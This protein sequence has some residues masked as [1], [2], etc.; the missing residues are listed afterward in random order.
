M[1]SI[2]LTILSMYSI[3]LFS[4]AD[5]L[6]IPK[7]VK[8][9][10][11]LQDLEV[12]SSHKSQL[13][14][15]LALLSTEKINRNEL[16]KAACCNVSESFSTNPSVDIT[17][18]DAATGAKQI[19]LL[20]LSGSYVQLQTENIPNLRGLSSNYGMDFI[21][22]TW[23]ESIQITKGTGSVMNGYEAM[24]GQIN[25][26]Y[27]KPFTSDPISVNVYANDAGR[28]EGNTEVSIRLNPN[29]GTALML[30]YSKD[31]VELDENSDG[32]SDLPMKTQYNFLNRWFY[33]K[34]GYTFQAFVKAVSDDRWSG[35]LNKK[36]NIDIQT[37]RYEFFVKNGYVFNTE[38]Y[39][40]LGFILSGNT[41]QQDAIYGNSSFLGNQNNLYLN[42][43]YDNSLNSN[44]DLKTG[45]SV[46]Y[47]T[48]SEHLIKNLV[49]V[50]DVKELTPG[51]FGEVHG[52][53]NE[54]IHFLGGIRLDHHSNFGWKF[55]PRASFKFIPSEHIQWRITAGTA[56]K[57][58]Y[59]LSEYNYYLASNRKIE[60]NEN[61]PFLEQ[62]WNLGSSLTG[63]IHIGEKE[64][65]LSGEWYYTNFQDQLLADLDYDPHQVL[66][67]QLQG[68]SYS[69]VLQFE[70]GIDLIEGLNVKGAYRLMDVKSTYS[71]ILREKPLQSRYKGLFALSYSTLGKIWQID[72]TAQFNGG[73]RMPL[74]DINNS[75]WEQEFKP[76]SVYNVQLTKNYKNL[77]L[78]SGI[79]NIFNF[80]QQ[81]P[82][83]DAVHPESD[84]FDATMI[85]GPTHGRKIY[86][87]LR[88]NL[89]QTEL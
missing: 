89:K 86:V 46:N 77:A 21:P 19:K 47:D 44:I 62:S 35:T 80:V 58:A 40:S 85:W 39:Q 61:V 26:E 75:L 25:V 70:A 3:L 36:F 16:Q 32:Y 38:N 37:D 54:T 67:Y 8:E 73:G 53:I 18:S 34:N 28:V 87:G 71:G 64:L 13:K 2:F 63:Q 10:V 57:S 6:Y 43:I 59:P 33:Q 69:S 15:K 1:K 84:N 9:N 4:Q 66:F 12:V 76:F 68:K 14:S 74:Y 11:D 20:G 78:Y 55:T 82:I 51:I 60:L 81:N 79:E 42:L 5:T 23:M 49:Y 17:Y 88:W 22:G 56:F 83:I 45:I 48:F 65:E 72:L 50:S 7:E 30:H 27:K 41:H 24:A 52:K 31:L 29:L